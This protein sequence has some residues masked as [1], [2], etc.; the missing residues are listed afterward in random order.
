MKVLVVM[1]GISSEKEISIKSGQ[2]I[3]QILKQIYPDTE[4]Y[5]LS[6]LKEFYMKVLTEKYDLIFLSLH[7]KYGEDGTIQSFLESLNI[8]FTFSNSTASKIAMNK[9]ICNLLVKEFISTYN[10]LNLKI[11]KTVHIRKNE[12]IQGG[13]KLVFSKLKNNF[14]IPPLIVKPNN[15]GSSIGISL[16]TNNEKIEEE[17][18][19]AIE[20]AFE[21]DQETI[22]IQEFIKG[23]EITVGVV[24]KVNEIIPLEPC[25]LE[26]ESNQIFD[27]E[28]KYIKSINHIIPPDLP[29]TTLDYLKDLSKRIFEF[30]GFK[31]AAR[32]DYKLTKEGE[33]YFLE[34]NTIPGFTQVSLLPQEAEK[35][36]ISFK[37]L[38]QI[39]VKNNINEN[40]KNPSSNN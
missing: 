23:R 20:I 34:V 31:D 17:L 37:E 19:K 26:I 15:S 3:Y 24:Q 38:L 10:I 16:V 7:G 13:S 33:I 6:D 29:S 22:L 32:I 18:Q 8:P 40:Q 25:E 11:P 9:M 12:Y 1:G 30:I 5:I 39:I 21:E 14:L 36:G 28:C 2:N 4:Q 35:T 27:Y